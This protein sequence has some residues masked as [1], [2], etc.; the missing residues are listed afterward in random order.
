MKEKLKTQNA[1]FI[2]NK[3]VVDSYNVLRRNG[4]TFSNYG[5]EKKYA[6]NTQLKLLEKAIKNKASAF[7]QFCYEPYTTLKKLSLN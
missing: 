7:P 3:F 6:K 2:E 5:L 4:M 1:E